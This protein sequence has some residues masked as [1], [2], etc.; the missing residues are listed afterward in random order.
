MLNESKPHKGRLAYWF[1]FDNAMVGFH[2]DHAVHPDGHFI[3]TSVVM[4]R[5]GNEIETLNSRYTLIG[6][7]SSFEEALAADKKADQSRLLLN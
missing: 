6:Q 4:N 5:E 1:P 2:L 3:I 7:Q